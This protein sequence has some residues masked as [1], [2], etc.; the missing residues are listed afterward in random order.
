MSI[1]VEADSIVG[2]SIVGDSVVD[3]SVEYDFAYN[4]AFS[5][6]NVRQ[7]GIFAGVNTTSITPEHCKDLVRAI[8]SKITKVEK[9]S[10]SLSGA[11]DSRYYGMKKIRH[12]HDQHSLIIK[13]RKTRSL[14]Q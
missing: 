1:L 3:D 12:F 8:C 4:A 5:S 9:M 13:N 2:D 10:W 11:T 6:V 14:F 7:D